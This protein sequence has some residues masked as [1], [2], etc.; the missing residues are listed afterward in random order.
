MNK[1]TYIKP[2]IVVVNIAT[3]QVLA[4]SEPKLGGT[5]EGGSVY[6]SEYAGDDEE[7][8]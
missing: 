8:W 4:G 2:N 7:E 3:Q 5:Y 1:K 6:S